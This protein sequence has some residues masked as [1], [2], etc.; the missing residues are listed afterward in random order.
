MIVYNLRGRLND[1]SEIDFREMSGERLT[2]DL[3]KN[4]SST[5]LPKGL[6]VAVPGTIKGLFEAHQRYGRFVYQVLNN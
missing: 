6:K 2:E 4:F 5:S 1:S 3:L